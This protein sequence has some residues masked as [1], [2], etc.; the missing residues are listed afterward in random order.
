MAGFFNDCL[1]SGLPSFAATSGTGSIASPARSGSS[2]WPWCRC[3]AFCACSA[4]ARAAST[5]SDE[6]NSDGDRFGCRLVA[7]FLALSIPS[8]TSDCRQ[9]VALAAVA[10]IGYLF[11]HR[12][13][14]IRSAALDAQRQQRTGAAV[15]HRPADWKRSP[16]HCVRTWPA[17]TADWPVSRR[18]S[19]AQATGDDQ[20]W[21]QLCSEAESMLRA[22]DAI[23]RAMSLAY[24]AIRQQSDALETFTQART[25]PLTGVGNGRALEEK[26]GVLLAAASRGGAEF[27][28][29][30][31][32]IDRD[33]ATAANDV[34]A[35]RKT[36]L[37]ELARL[38]QSC[39]RE[40]DF[41]ARYGDDEFVVRDAAD[42]ARRRLRVR[43]AAAERRGRADGGDGELRHRRISGGGRWEVAAWAGPIRRFTA[44]RRRAGIDSLSTRGR[45]SASTVNAA[46]GRRQRAR[47]R[48][49]PMP[50]VGDTDG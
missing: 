42:E 14:K 22:D 31:V 15:G 41:V 38:I 9:T 36:Q 18:L 17:T 7:A 12:T 6:Q 30:L 2:C 13:R 1:T 39:M 49:L 45:R 44:P 32:S 10:L 34:R 3:S 11:G 33:P 19:E 37:P 24:D 21:K 4:T 20:A 50:L 5:N 46:R 27:S 28:M 29:A 35:E 25:D 26:L 40:D 47:T 16:A 43:R 8:S 23:G 48:A